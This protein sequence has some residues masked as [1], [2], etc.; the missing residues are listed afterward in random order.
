LLHEN[1]VIRPVEIK[2]AATF[3]REALRGLEKWRE[4][5]GPEAG[6]PMLVY[7]GSE[8]QPRS[9][10]DVVSWRAL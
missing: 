1:G 4:I 2:S 9:E 7:G 3:Q 10:A 5:A 6:R 8:S